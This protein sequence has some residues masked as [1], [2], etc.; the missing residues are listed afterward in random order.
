[1]EDLIDQNA[2]LE[3]FDDMNPALLGGHQLEIY[4]RLKAEAEP[5]APEPVQHEP[6][7]EPAIDLFSR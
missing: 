4:N 7:Y 2:K 3:D 1:M 5:K 6:H